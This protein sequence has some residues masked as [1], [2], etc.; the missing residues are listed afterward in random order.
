MKKGDIIIAVSVII[1]AAV[2][3]LVFLVGGTK[4]K[5]V[6]IKQSESVIGTY[7]LKKDKVIELGTNTIE[8]KNG[9]VE[10]IWTSCKNHICK[11]HLPI[12]KSGESIVCL[13]NKIIVTIEK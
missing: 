7:S 13:P 6:V 2:V 12:S 10:V 9:K 4:G 3:F 1:A 5:N 8:I 11:K